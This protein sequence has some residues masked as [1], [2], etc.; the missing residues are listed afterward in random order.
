VSAL[1]QLSLITRARRLAAQG[2][3]QEAVPL[4][5]RALEAEPDNAI[6]AVELAKSLEKLGR[7]A[8]AV[9]VLEAMRARRPDDFRT[10]R[11]LAFAY[12]SAG[13]RAEGL[14]AQKAIAERHP[15]ADSLVMVG[16]LLLEDSRPLEAEP[17]FERAL[18]LDPFAWEATAG[19]VQIL[20]ADPAN[21]ARARE[22]I[23][24]A[25]RMNPTQPELL[26]ARDDLADAATE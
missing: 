25:L 5:E 7:P 22:L 21:Y 11:A 18:A 26:K 16:A 1:S 15:R 23:D 17:Y 10:E 8:D 3:H 24:E 2:A 13:R 14:A 12:V 19:L 20:T 4:Y 9:P 6:L